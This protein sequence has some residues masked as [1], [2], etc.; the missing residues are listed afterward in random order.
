[1]RRNGGRELQR[2]QIDLSGGVLVTPMTRNGK[3]HSLPI[4]PMMR[5]ILERRCS[6]LKPDGELLVGVIAEHLDNMAMRVGPPRFMRHDLRKTMATVV[7]KLGIRDAVL[8]RI[9]GAL[10]DLMLSA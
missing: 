4:T 3:S 5:D 10:T 2:K 9:Q 1:M 6:G 8:V 7:E